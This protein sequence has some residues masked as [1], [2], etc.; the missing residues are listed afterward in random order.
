MNMKEAGALLELRHAPL[1]ARRLF[2]RRWI[3]RSEG[4]SPNDPGYDRTCTKY[5]TITDRMAT[6]LFAEV[7][8]G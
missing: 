2:W 8:G 3:H 4:R 6:V 7:F 1:A 5:Q